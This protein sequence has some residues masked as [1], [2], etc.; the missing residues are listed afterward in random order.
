MPTVTSARTSQNAESV[1]AQVAEE[2]A[3]ELVEIT[4]NHV[5]NMT[6]QEREQ[7]L[8]D[9]NAYVSSLGREAKPSGPR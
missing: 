3:N 6:E 9:L 4:R 1:I 7:R 2:L 5:E 8:K